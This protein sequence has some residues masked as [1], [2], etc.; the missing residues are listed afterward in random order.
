VFVSSV[1]G[2]VDPAVDAAPGLWIAEVLH[3]FARD[4]GSIIPPG[5]PR[6]ALIR[7]QSADNA[8]AV[9]GHP[10]TELVELLA[11]LGAAHTSTP[12]RCW[13]ALWDG[14]GWLTSQRMYWARN[15]QNAL[16]RILGRRQ[17]RVQRRRDD[18]RR[19]QVERELLSIPKLALPQRTYLLFVGPVAAACAFRDP[20]WPSPDPEPPNLWWP[21]DRAW[22]VA[23]EIDLPVSYVG[24]TSDLIE[25]VLRE[26]GELAAPVTPDDKI[27]GHT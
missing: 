22:C 11:N 15:G 27:F 16:A 4:V 3:P 10:P 12:D 20:M 6:Y 19:R 23:S 24:G 25:A 2:D 14:R 7:H 13:F 18:S 17:L 9:A 26:V 21:D 5:F 1:F 8:E